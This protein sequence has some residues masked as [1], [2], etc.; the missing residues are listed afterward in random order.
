MKS[1]DELK[2]IAADAA[3]TIADKSL[4][5]A[6]KAADKTKT[7]AKIAKLSAEVAGE[8]ESIKKNYAEI[9]RLYCEKYKDNPDEE[10]AQ[11]VSEVSISMAII[12]SK[13]AEIEELKASSDVSEAEECSCGEECKCDEDCE[14]TCE[15]ECECSEE[16]KCEEKTKDAE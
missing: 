7:A 2:K 16:P 4:I 14:C 8:K 15:E 11:A 13:K 1:F 3:G 9:G 10:L 12:E 5:F 6:K